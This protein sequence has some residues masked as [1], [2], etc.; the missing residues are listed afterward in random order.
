LEDEDRF[1]GR[2]SVDGSE[3]HE[4][5]SRV[6]EAESKSGL[7]RSRDNR[8][9]VAVAAQVGDVQHQ[10][11]TDGKSTVR[12]FDDRL[13]KSSYRKLQPQKTV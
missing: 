2:F 1:D 6:N 8:D 7:H 13:Q 4:E 5:G 11:P 12:T 9:G 3:R 10:V